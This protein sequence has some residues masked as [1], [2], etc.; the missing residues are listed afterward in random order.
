MTGV[1]IVPVTAERWDDFARL[2]GKKGA[3]RGCWCM[4]WRQTGVEH[5]RGRDG[6]NR[7]AMRRLVR[8]NRVPGLLAYADDEPVG[9]ISVAPRGEFG[10]I[11]RSRVIGPIDE[12]PVWSIVCFYLRP[13]QRGRGIGTALLEAAARHARD[14]G[15]RLVEAYPIDPQ[16]KEPSGVELFTGPLRMFER[17][18]FHEVARRSPRR[19]IVRREVR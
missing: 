5:E 8:A 4:W 11:E 13:D 2:F 16:G 14:G 19:P 9:W 10:R 18:G 3:Y 7:A 15:A 6:G 17:A 12:E 1:Q